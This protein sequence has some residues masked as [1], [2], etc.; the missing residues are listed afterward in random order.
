MRC[1]AKILPAAL[2]CCLFALG[3]GSSRSPHARVMNASPDSPP[4]RVFVGNV[5]IDD[6]LPFRAVSGYDRI[7]EGF[8]DVAVFASHTNDLL[9]EGT[10][11][12]AQR[13]DFTLIVLDSVQFLDA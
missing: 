11:L 7:D 3:C 9:L 12:F 2:L 6:F 1:R 5:E 13:Q 4:L 8:N 10:P